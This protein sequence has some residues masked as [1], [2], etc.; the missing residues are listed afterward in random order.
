MRI[1]LTAVD[2]TSTLAGIPK[3]SP[4]VL[5]Q[6]TPVAT[7]PEEYFFSTGGSGQIGGTN[8][9]ARPESLAC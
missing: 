4:D 2:L 3:Y 9:T 7:D 8:V 6:L 5:Q 1:F